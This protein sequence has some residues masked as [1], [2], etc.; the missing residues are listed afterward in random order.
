MWWIAWILVGLIVLIAAVYALR[1]VKGMSTAYG[2]LTEF[3]EEASKVKEV[4]QQKEQFFINKL[5][6]SGY[7]REYFKQ[8]RDKAVVIAKKA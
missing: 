8:L 1:H 5:S 4:A 7:N 2:W 6:A 3:T